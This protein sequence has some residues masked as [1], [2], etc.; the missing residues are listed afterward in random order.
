MKKKLQIFLLSLGAKI[1]SDISTLNI[2]WC[3]EYKKG[4]K[5]CAFE[6]EHVSWGNAQIR[7]R[8]AKSATLKSD[9]CG[10]TY[11]F[12]LLYNSGRL[13]SIWV[14]TTEWEEETHAMGL[15]W[16][17]SENM[18]THCLEQ[19]QGMEQAQ[20]ILDLGIMLRKEW[21]AA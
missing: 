4:N 19:N 12:P 20:E 13:L 5:K 10:F 8:K 1:P 6:M 15:L 14:P 3:N 21:A 7:G 18:C 11:C 9:R 2:T 17:I 16:R